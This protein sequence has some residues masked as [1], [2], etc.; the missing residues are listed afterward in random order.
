MNNELI[1]PIKIYKNPTM[2]P[3]SSRNKLAKVKS[4]EIKKFDAI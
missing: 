1:I 2:H 3:S 4:V